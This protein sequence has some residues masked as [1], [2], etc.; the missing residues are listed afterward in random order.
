MSDRCICKK[1]ETIRVVYPTDLNSYE[2]EAAETLANR[3]SDMTGI[4]PVLMHGGGV[5]EGA[6]ALLIGKTDCEESR[7]AMSDILYGEGLLRICG[8][9]VVFACHN[10]DVLPQLVPV[11]L[12]ALGEL[13]PQTGLVLP[14]C[15]D[16]TR[17]WD[18]SYLS[19]LPVCPFGS[20]V[21]VRNTGDDCK[22]LVLGGVAAEQYTAY[23]KMLNSGGFCQLSSREINGNRFA[24]F[25]KGDG[26]FHVNFT[27]CNGYLRLIAEPLRN[28][29]IQLPDSRRS[30]TPRLFVTGCRF[31]STAR[32][33]GV[34]SGAGN[35]SYA[36]RLSN[37][38]FLLI[39][40]GMP[41][42]SYADAMMKILT[43]N[44]PD[45]EHIVIAAW[46]ITH[47]HGDHTGC[48]YRFSEKYASGK[49]VT[50]R[51][52]V[53]NFPS[54]QDAECYRELWQIRHVKEY[55]L[56]YWNNTPLKKVHVGDLLTLADA[57][58]DFLYT[59]E[60]LVRQ[61]F[62]LLNEKEY[63]NASLFFKIR[64]ADETIMITGDTEN[65]ANDLIVAM[66]G[67]TLK[68][69]LL[70][71]CHHGGRGGT[72][73]LYHLI[74]PEVAFFCTSES[75]YPKY[76]MLDY[77]YAL[78]YEQHLKEAYNADETTYVFDLPYHA[79]SRRIPPFTGTRTYKRAA[80]LESLAA[81]EADAESAKK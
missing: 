33:L 13:E 37:G 43:E 69:D 81:M 4:R 45:P 34:D 30:C 15:L 16:Y 2:F 49:T 78:V 53:S 26:L 38:E 19:R 5:P 70:Q 71:V 46:M 11:F 1:G 54:L 56:T 23:L 66:Y 14:E 61:Y 25:S 35:M 6:P 17:V 12:R 48:F 76:L 28:A 79:Q 62:S 50:I 7:L 67:E 57:E 68:S 65:T 8:N 42:D 64:I 77:N 72:R 44:A 29:P 40:G 52:L 21:N 41:T 60:E 80:Y 73:A 39:D 24:S 10:G 59:H 22:M 9:R 63:N 47:T 55:L 51:Q 3:L 75:L 36:I 31:S 58:I 20:L 18:G 74:D 32:Y 27:P